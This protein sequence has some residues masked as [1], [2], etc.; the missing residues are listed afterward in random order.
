MERNVEETVVSNG[1]VP[2]NKRIE[3]EARERRFKIY[4]LRLSGKTYEEIGKEMGINKQR[5]YQL[6]RSARIEFQR[7]IMNAQRYWSTKHEVPSSD[8]CRV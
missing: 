1:W 2:R 8:P 5:A 7:N 4:G 6:Q 3:Q